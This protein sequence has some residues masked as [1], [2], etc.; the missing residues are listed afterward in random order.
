MNKKIAIENY[1]S[2]ILFTLFLYYEDFLCEINAC[3]EYEKKE[4]EI[5]REI[6]VTRAGFA[7]TKYIY[8]F[9]KKSF[10]PLE[11]RTQGTKR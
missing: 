4:N 3:I 2:T 7:C 1:R 10:R 11:K 9:I 8:V 6:K 5:R